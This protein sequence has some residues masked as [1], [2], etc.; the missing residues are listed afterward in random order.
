MESN[1]FCSYTLLSQNVSLQHT[2]EV[3]VEQN[4]R[5]TTQLNVL[6]LAERRRCAREAAIAARRLAFAF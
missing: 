6:T 5:L 3:V 1:S 4:Q 2:L